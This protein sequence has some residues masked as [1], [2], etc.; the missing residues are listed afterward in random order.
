M[1]MIKRLGYSVGEAYGFQWKYEY[2]PVSIFTRLDYMYDT[3]HIHIGKCTCTYMYM[4]HRK[5]QV[6]L[7]YTMFGQS[8]GAQQLPVHATSL[9]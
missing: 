5:I 8:P 9:L 3:S 2:K 6:S 4:H 7:V 1:A